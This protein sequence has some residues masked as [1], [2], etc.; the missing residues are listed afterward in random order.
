MSL[1]YKPYLIFPDLIEQPTWGGNYIVNLKKL[2]SPA[3]NN[4]KIGQSYELYSKSKLLTNIKDPRSP[5]LLAPL[6]KDRD[7]FIL[8]EKINSP[9]KILIKLTQA[10]GNSFQLHTK[11][12]NQNSRWQSKA[13]TWF[14]LK[15]G[16]ATLGIKPQ[17]NLQQYQRVCL[18]I[19]TQMQKL[20]QNIQQKTI[21]LTLAKQTAA[22]LIKKLNP[23]QFVNLVKIKKNQVVDLS[24]CGIHHSWEENAQVIPE[25]N[26]VYEIQQDVADEISSIRSFDKGKFKNDGTIRPVH[27]DDYFV[28]LDTK[29]ENNSP[30][31]LIKTPKGENI[32]A[33]KYYYLDILN[34]NKNRSFK[35][36]NLFHHLFV[37]EGEIE[38]YAQE[39]KLI[40]PQGFSCFIPQ[41]VTHY[42]LICRQPKTIVLKSYI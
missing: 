31:N 24:A 28:N 40:L 10:L 6:K 7:Y 25:G 16:L 9:L 36:K 19:D 5:Q 12:Q 30:S 27:I 18:E 32:I 35:N 22:N 15:D 37:S 13:E 8:E 42:T 11:P 21:S 23:W 1:L 3:F 33:N 4:K 41:A 29:L 39:E 17:C 34:L 26:I 2:K 38:I 14:F 20:S